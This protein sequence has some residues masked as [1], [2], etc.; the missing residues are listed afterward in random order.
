ML[1]RRPVCG[2]V[3]DV[4]I[5]RTLRS[6]DSTRQIPCTRGA[7]MAAARQ[8][9]PDQPRARRRPGAGPGWTRGRDPCGAVRPG[10]VASRRAAVGR[11][12]AAVAARRG[13]TGDAP[14]YSRVSRGRGAAAA[15]G[16]AA[17][18]RRRDYAAT[19][20]RPPLPPVPVVSSV[21]HAPLSVP[22]WVPRGAARRA[23]RGAGGRNACATS[24]RA[25][26]V[27]VRNADPPW[28]NVRRFRNYDYID[29]RLYSPPLHSTR[30]IGSS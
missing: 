11:G 29:G 23:A 28:A 3:C 8:P 19:P 30:Q 1:S 27:R 18:R 5:N 22:G 9:F 21:E 17:P 10:V 25:R 26:R 13:P 2:T 20:P 6:R 15:G 14:G 4:N 12:G 7:A 16:A 24:N